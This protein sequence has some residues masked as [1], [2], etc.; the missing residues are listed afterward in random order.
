MKKN[1]LGITIIV[2]A[3]AIVLL[4]LEK[5]KVSKDLST[6]G[7]DHV[8]IRVNASESMAATTLPEVGS[9][10]PDFHLTTLEGKTV[11]LSDFKGKKVILN[12]WATWCPPCK[13]EIPHM[14][15]FYEKNKDKDVIILAVNLTSEE[16]GQAAIEKFVKKYDLTFPILLDKE[17]QVGETYQTFTIPTSYI[18]DTQGVINKKIVGPMDEEMMTKFINDAR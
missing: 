1:L 17:G 11:K 10:P 12:F 18:V 13:A 3:I 9:V 7:R 8:G 6:G 5:P 4:N 16:N 2:I 14:Q 15:R